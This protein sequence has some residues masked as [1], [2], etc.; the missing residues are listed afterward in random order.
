[1]MSPFPRHWRWLLRAYPRSQRRRQGDEI[2]TTVADGLPPGTRRLPFLVAIDLVLGGLRC[3]HERRPPFL[4]WLR[5]RASGGRLEQRY[6]AWL[7]DDLVRPYPV[8]SLVVR[9]SGWAALG[10][11]VRLATQGSDIGLPFMLINAL[12]AGQSVRLTRS[13]R[14]RE[15]ARHGYSIDGVHR[16]GVWVGRAPVG[17]L[18]PNYAMGRSLAAVGWTLLLAGPLAVAA[19]HWRRSW[20]SLIHI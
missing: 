16:P 19:A 6:H 10:L 11:G 9:V 20:L 14:G 5:Y 3:R 17:P 15:L 18:L 8:R 12:L 7:L 4:D 1:M 2:L 13:G